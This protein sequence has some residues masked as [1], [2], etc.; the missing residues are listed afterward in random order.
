MQYFYA[1][2]SALS[3]KES[4][5]KFRNTS[6]PYKIKFLLPPS[7]HPLQKL[8]FSQVEEL[9]MVTNLVVN[10]FKGVYFYSV[11]PTFYSFVYNYLLCMKI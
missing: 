2:V 6:A 9:G 10:I 11:R 8:Y 3:A 1:A 4:E 7:H 5:I